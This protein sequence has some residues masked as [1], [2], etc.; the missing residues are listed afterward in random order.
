ML[1]LIGSPPLSGMIGR[2]RPTS[3]PK[4]SVKNRLTAMFGRRLGRLQ[5]QCHYAFI[6]LGGEART[7]ELAEWRWPERVLLDGRPITEYQGA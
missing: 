7:S 1:Y 6:A 5:R 4:V 3:A 2:A